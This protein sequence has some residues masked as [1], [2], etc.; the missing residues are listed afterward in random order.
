MNEEQEMEI[1]AL[2]SIYPEK[3]QLLSNDP[4][5]FTLDIYPTEEEEENHGF[6]FL[7]F[8]FFLFPSYE[9]C[10]SLDFWALVSYYAY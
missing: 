4:A 8:L 9:P 5:H 10:F 6:S 2:E 7:L 1:E 3:F